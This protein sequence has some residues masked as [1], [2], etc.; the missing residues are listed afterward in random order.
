MYHNQNEINEILGNVPYLE[1]YVHVEGNKIVIFRPI[2]DPVG[3][4]VFFGQARMGLALQIPGVPVPILSERIKLIH[5]A[6]S[7]LDEAVVLWPQIA[8]EEHK[9][10]EREL[11]GPSIAL[12]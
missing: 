8:N 4:D 9:K 3:Q 12:P 2:S 7:T 10:F 6:C 5:L 1:S 11:T